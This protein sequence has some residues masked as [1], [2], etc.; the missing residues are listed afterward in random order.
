MSTVQ[1]RQIIRF[2]TSFF[3]VLL[4]LVSPY[5]W[6]Q[7]LPGRTEPAP[8]FRLEQ[9]GLLALSPGERRAVLLKPNKQMLVLKPGDPVPGTTAVLAQVLPDKLVFDEAPAAGQAKQVVWMYKTAA[10]SRLERYSALAPTP[11]V[12]APQP[13]TLSTVIRVGDG[14]APVR[15]RKP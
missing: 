3:I 11:P 10:G 7:S 8:A 13:V 1:N 15:D 5:G 4:T 12:P 2:T 14:A 6:A 9:F